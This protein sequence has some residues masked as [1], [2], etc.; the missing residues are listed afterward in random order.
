L[1]PRGVRGPTTVPACQMR[2]GMSP[3]RAIAGASGRLPTGLVPRAG[4]P[5]SGRRVPAGCTDRV[6]PV[7]R[8]AGTV[9][10]AAPGDGAQLEQRPADDQDDH[11]ALTHRP[12][13]RSWAPAKAITR[14]RPRTRAARR[15]QP[16][17]P[18]NI[19]LI[20]IFDGGTLPNG[21]DGRVCRARVAV[22][23]R[24]FRTA[25]R[26]TALASLRAAGWTPAWRGQVAGRAAA[27]TTSDWPQ[28][29][30]VSTC[31]SPGGGEWKRLRQGWLAARSRSQMIALG[32]SALPAAFQRPSSARY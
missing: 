16:H 30:P 4:S 17:S 22:M 8:A 21:A 10:V 25:P 7:R 13:K 26:P 19:A 28:R 3:L 11:R 24:G 32:R 15:Q 18:V 23:R 12:K 9:T 14:C 5:L 31:C 6:V 29:L 2:P 1:E 20:R 27:S